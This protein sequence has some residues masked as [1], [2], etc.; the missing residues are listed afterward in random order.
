MP[1]EIESE[2]RSFIFKNILFLD[3]GYALA[4]HTSFVA[5]G[6]IDSIGV[7]ELAEF[8]RTQF[9]FDVPLRDITP[10]NFDSI[11]GLASY[12]RRRL[13]ERQ[14]SSDQLAGPDRRLEVNGQT[15]A[16][17]CVVADGQVCKP[18]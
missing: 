14:R 5:E 15:S 2:L 6:V 12:V 13:A 8:I 9:G 16:E 17:A 10:A 3:D 7:T 1:P 4:D 18:T 11:G